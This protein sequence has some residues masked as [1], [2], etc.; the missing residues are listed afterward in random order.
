[1]T[2]VIGKKSRRNHTYIVQDYNVLLSILCLIKRE[3]LVIRL[4]ILACNVAREGHACDSHFLL[5]VIL[6]YPHKKCV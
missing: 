1:M 4:V 6:D 5:R 2:I 3:C